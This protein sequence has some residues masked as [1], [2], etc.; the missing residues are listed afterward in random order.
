MKLSIYLLRDNYSELDNFLK[1]KYR[2]NEVPIDELEPSEA[3]PYESR[4]FLLESTRNTPRWAKYVES[5]FPVTDLK[6]TNYSF[7]HLLKASDRIFALTFGYGHTMLDTSRMEPNFGL[8]VCANVIDP[9][10]LTTLDVRNIDVVT[11]QQRTHLSA[12]ADVLDF[13]IELEE[14]WIRFLSG[15]PLDPSIADSIAGADALKIKSEVKLEDLAQKCSTILNLY[16]SDRYKENFSFLDHYRA[17]GKKDPIIQYLEVELENRILSQSTAKISIASP[18][19]PDE[20]NIDR[21]KIYSGYK[22]NYF[23][24]LKLEEVYRFLTSY[25]DIENPLE[26]AH[27]IPLD[28]DDNPCAKS[29]S[30]RDYMVC[31]VA[32]EDNVFVLSA[33]VWFRVNSDYAQ[34]VREKARQIQDL[35][36]DLALIPL[37]PGES[38]KD[39]NERLS[40]E[41]NWVKMDR[42]FISINEPYQRVEV[43]DVMANDNRLLC[44]KKMTRSSTLSHLFAQAS[45]SAELLRGDESY[46]SQII[47]IL[48]NA[49]RSVDIENPKP[50]F[51][52]SFITEKEGPLWESIFLFS[53][54][55]LVR[56]TQFIQRLGFEVAIA[57]I[58]IE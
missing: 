19:M 48:Q 33:G 31:E 54:I 45:V 11:K 20:Q 1:E 2:N 34:S 6:I 32:Y 17:I 3:L 40:S 50:T 55:H 52:L 21:Y 7:V 43:C 16:N 22:K 9:A 58:N 49:G 5:H 51:V 28:H 29:A 24:E 26:K 46:K 13:G 8:K 25:P 41:R 12:A 39:Y 56:Q 10:R 30:L 23:T 36:T 18:E 37:S 44:I 14:E 42:D 15:V 38:E 47:K 57:K 53:A 27:I 4:T 35:T